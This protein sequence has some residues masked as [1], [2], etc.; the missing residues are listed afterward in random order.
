MTVVLV[1]NNDKKIENNGTFFLSEGN[2]IH[3]IRS[4]NKLRKFIR[5][6]IESVEKKNQKYE[7]SGL[8]M[9]QNWKTLEF[10]N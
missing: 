8:I 4:K 10:Q 7:L 6:G 5:V 2:R 1:N 9:Y 3:F